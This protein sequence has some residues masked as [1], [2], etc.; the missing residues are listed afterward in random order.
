MLLSAVIGTGAAWLVER[1]DLPGRRVWHVLLVAPLAVPA[2]VNSFGWV[3]L[4]ARVEGYRRRAADRD[5]VLL[6]AR[7]PAGRRG[8]ARARPGLEETGALARASAAGATF[9]RVV[10]PQLRPALLG[11]ALLVA[12]HLLAEFGALQ[13]LRY[14]TFTTAIYDQYQSTFN[15]PAA[16]MLA[17]VLVL[18][19]PAAAAAELRP[20]RARAATPGVGGGAPAP[21]AARAGSAAAVL[22]VLAGLTA[23]VVLALGVPIGSLRALAG[24]RHLDGVPARRCCQRPPC[25]LARPRRW[26]ARRSPSLLA[27]PVAWLAV[28]HRGRF[29]AAARAQHLRRP[30]AARA[31]WSRWPWSRSRSGA[32]GRSTRPRRCCSPAY[33][34]LFLPAG[35][36]QP[37]GR[38]GPGAAGARRRRRTRSAPARS[39]TL[40]RV[41]L[42]LI[43]PGPRRRRGAGLPRGGHRADR[44]AAA[45]PDRHPDAGDPVLEP[46]AAA[47][48]TARPR[49]T[50][51]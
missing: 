49:R 9:A 32:P 37:A 8:A 45:R 19:L 34:I 29:A 6:P 1:T 35:H 22:P 10:L 43:A 26:P 40:R 44:H 39:A 33:A 11:G 31:S 51:R 13:M 16:T 36:G 3:S 24:R 5:A 23:L 25:T 48:P 2:F 46:D 47:S 30:R 15:G 42:P 41:T 28:R 27:L 50:R 18:L 20:A 17:G 7:L 21:V 38:A 14:P 12:L 4:D